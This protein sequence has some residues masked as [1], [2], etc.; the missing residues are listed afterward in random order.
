MII[1]TA[2]CLLALSFFTACTTTQSTA[3]R[4]TLADRVLAQNAAIAPVDGLAPVAEGP[5]DVPA[6]RGIDPSRNPAL[7]PTPLLR[8][9]AAGGL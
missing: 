7:L 1:K 5:E 6:D 3:G 2:T 4:Q 8:T 9:S